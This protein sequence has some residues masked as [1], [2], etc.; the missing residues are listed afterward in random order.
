MFENGLFM[1]IVWGT[2][3]FSVV[4]YFTAFV[5]PGFFRK[6]A[7]SKNTLLFNI[8]VGISGFLLLPVFVSLWFLAEHYLFTR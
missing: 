2:A 1:T 4:W 7:E 3:I 5:C 6:L 8:C